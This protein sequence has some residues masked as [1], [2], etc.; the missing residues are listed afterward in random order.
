MCFV[1]VVVSLQKCLSFHLFQESLL[2]PNGA[3]L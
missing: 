2:V 3:C 1:V